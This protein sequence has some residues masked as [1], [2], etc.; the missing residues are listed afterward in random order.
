MNLKY[1]LLLILLIS[2]KISLSQSNP[3]MD[4]IELARNLSYQKKFN[5]AADLLKE[6][7]IRHPKS[8]NSVRL[9]AQVLS[10]MKDSEGAL[11]LLAHAMEINPNPYVQLD[12]ARMLFDLNRLDESK[13]MMEDYLKKDSQNVEALNTLGTIAYWQGEPTKAKDYFNKVIKQ[14][15]A[16]EQALKYVREINDLSKPFIN[17]SGGYGN[18]TQPLSVVIGQIETGW[19]Q[20]KYL[21][22]KLALQAKGY[23][24]NNT[25][26]SFYGLELGNKF[27]LTA[28]KLDILISGGMYKSPV[29][30]ANG[31][32]GKLE[33][34]QK[35]SSIFSLSASA[36]HQPYFYT[37]SSL[38]KEVTFDNY[39]LALVL[40]KPNGWLGWAGYNVQQFMDQNRISS[41]GAWLLLPP[42]KFSDFKFAL[43]YYYNYANADQDYFIAATP[44]SEAVVTKKV[45]GVYDPYF[46]PINQTE[47]S[48]LGSFQFKPSEVFSISLNSRVGFY[49]IAD[50]P[51]FTVN[52]GVGN[53]TP[54]KKDFYPAKFTPVE[55]NGAINIQVS[56]KATLHANYT[57][58]ETYFYNNSLASLGLYL[59]L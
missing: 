24:E 46:T 1:I 42:F 52:S 17:L 18:D 44:I 33:L 34:N 8:I 49:A 12:Y 35:L 7:E 27:S 20:S 14:Y 22:P 15:P 21:A 6:Y 53:Q 3:Q 56:K 28:L 51:G 47:N 11:N 43:G 59:K 25:Q 54:Y 16:N 26:K 58:L 19:Y 40:N 41:Y 45:N 50:R 37:I 4:T 32:T 39:G 48:V 29:E 2:C 36:Q 38:Q 13:R 55:I 10:W 30:N 23:T 57:Y 31:W 9:H 5:E